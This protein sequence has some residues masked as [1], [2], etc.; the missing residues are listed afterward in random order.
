MDSVPE[1]NHS[2]DSGPAVLAVPTISSPIATAGTVVPVGSTRIPIAELVAGKNGGRAEGVCQDP[3]MSKCIHVVCGAGCQ[4]I[5]VTFRIMVGNEGV[6]GTTVAER[7][8][9]GLRATKGSDTTAL[10][11][12]LEGESVLE[13]LDL[14]DPCIFV[15]SNSGPATVVDLYRSSVIRYSVVPEDPYL[16]SDI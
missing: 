15:R 11:G 6:G 12:G 3:H 7:I 14:T 4:G 5:T 2:G 10:E 13:G 1:T 16:L 8:A 9:V